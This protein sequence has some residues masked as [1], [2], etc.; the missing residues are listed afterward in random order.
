MI[1]QS[2]ESLGIPESATSIADLVSRSD[3]EVLCEGI[4]A[5]GDEALSWVKD[6]AKRYKIEDG[7]LRWTPMF[8]HLQG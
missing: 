2:F 5:E 8:G 3:A 6:R 1:N 4:I 7:L